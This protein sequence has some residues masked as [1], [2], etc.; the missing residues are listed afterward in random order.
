VKIEDKIHNLRKEIQEHDYSYY[1]LSQPKISDF[2]YDQKMKK[3]VQLE[4]QRPDLITPDSPSQ[5]V[6]GEPTKEF[7]NVRHRLP[8]LSLANTYSEQDLRDFDNRVKGLLNTNENY[9]YVA[10]LKIDGLAV[11]LVY[12]DGIFIQGATRGDGT[13]GDD[14]TTNL[15]TIRSIPL[16]FLSHKN[17]KGVIEIRGEVFMSKDAFKKLNKKREE[18]GELLF[19]NPR[20]SAAGTLKMQDP[21]VVAQRGLDIFC[22]QLIN[23]T[24]PDSNMV[25]DQA[26]TKL[27]ELGLHVNPH[28]KKCA[29]MN[30]VLDYCHHW[31]KQRDSLP[32]EIDGVVIKINDRGQQLRLGHTSKSPRWAIAYKF[33]ASQ[34]KSKIMK[35]TWQ[36][37]RTGTITPVAELEPVLVAGTTVSRATLHNQEEIERKG[38]REGDAV[39]IEKGGDIIPKVVAVILTERAKDSRPYKIPELCPVCSTKLVKNVDEAALR[40]PN[41]SCPAQIVRRIEHFVSR[42]AMDIEGLGT[43]VVELFVEKGLI[44]DAAD[45]Y[46][47]TKDQISNLEG[48]GEKS[49]DN[50]IRSLSESKF[51]PLERFIFGLGIPY[52]GITAARTLARVFGD[53]D[54]LMFADMEKLKS[55]DGIGTKMAHSVYNFVHN[56]NN[57]RLIE[58]FRRAGINFKYES[59][60]VDNTFKNMTFVLTGTLPGLTRAEASKMILERGGK[61]SSSVSKSTTHLLAGEKAGSK[62]EKAKNLGI[63]ILDESEFRSLL[64]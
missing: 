8:M 58:K 61:V 18:E 10:E 31:E 55:V 5:R 25:H 47:L 45:L 6:S 27:R 12:E 36:V 11:S 17:F 40:C 26:L 60:E 41:Y 23:H 13:I 50:L 53:F 30:E 16:K 4:S 2:E 29:S 48:L 19:A 9:E 38:I 14:I 44:M 37:G 42:G 3:L 34:A 56:E 63:N 52:V 46:T 62:L 35:I 32:Y 51:R 54:S 22:Y 21:K 64:K 57:K 33:K 7:A 49:A 24:N 20:N 39:F 28:I 1:V 43:A 15:R 59:R